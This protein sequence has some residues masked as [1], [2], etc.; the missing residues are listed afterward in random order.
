[1]YLCRYIYEQMKKLLFSI[2]LNLVGT[3]QLSAYMR[4]YTVN[5][6]LPT[7]EVWQIVQLPNKQILVQSTGPFCLFD[8]KAFTTLHCDTTESYKLKHF[9]GYGYLKQGDSLLWLRDFYNLYLLDTRSNSFRTDIAGRLKSEELMG[10]AKYKE[11]KTDFAHNKYQNL[12][13]S[14]TGRTDMQVTTSCTDHEGGI[15]LGTI[16]NGIFYWKPLT[17]RC[18]TTAISGITCMAAI[19]DHE[20]VLGRTNDILLFD[21][22]LRKVTKTIAAETGLCHDASTDKSGTAWIS[23]GKGLYQY[24]D[25]ELT[26]FDQ[27]N[28]K[29]FYHSEMRFATPLSDG[30][31]LVCNSLNELGYFYPHRREFVALKPQLPILDSYRVFIGSQ[32]LKEKKLHAIYS[33]NGMLVLDVSTNKL[34]GEPAP[35]EKYNCIFVDSKNRLWAGMPNGLTLLGK[36]R[37]SF[38]KADGLRNT[39]IKS[40]REDAYGNLWIGT[41]MGVAKMT[42]TEDGASFL[43]YNKK[44]GMPT[45]T[46]VERAA[47]TMASGKIWMA[48]TEGITEID[49]SLFHNTKIRQNVN[50]IDLETD[51]RQL[52]LTDGEVHVSYDDN[53]IS[54][55]FSTLNYSL[56]SETQYRYRLVGLDD[57]WIY[58][59]ETG[60]GTAQFRYLPP[61]EYTFEVQ[62]AY[63]NGEWG[64]EATRTI[65]VEPPFWLT[66]WAKLIYILIII[67]AIAIG[68]KMYLKRQTVKLAAKNEEKVNKLFELRAEAR[69]Q[70]AQN[71]N[72]NPEKLTINDEE[73]QIMTRLLKAIERNISNQEYTVDQMAADIALS[74]SNLYRRMQAMLGI[75]PNE[76]L[77]NVRLKHAARLLTETDMP[78]SK[79]SLA[80]GFNSP[81]YFSQYFRKMFGV[82]PSEY[83]QRGNG[84]EE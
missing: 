15:W 19:S 13:D 24:K 72:I 40:I 58:S 70:F 78:V 14:L 1:M 66:W 43:F 5:D 23:S 44:I 60:R 32:Q 57:K 63:D 21:T 80:V 42:M 20:I 25:G 71:V 41:S 22:E 2:L 10:F 9:A 7:N 54:I 39:Y 11:K 53:C 77:R 36:E 62:A 68:I 12:L 35:A 49:P 29:G 17:Q 27:N 8:G 26:H 47:V 74:R 55:K 67:S 4:H 76:F 82:T 30:R 81:R 18:N 51:F 3:L 28:T 38:G 64:Q 33:Q 48:G 50:I 52:P 45:T 37:K 73:E 65:I 31:I 83:G 79:V 75:T 16:N 46:M 34:V 56:E 6:G 61:G 59:D 84:I 69:H